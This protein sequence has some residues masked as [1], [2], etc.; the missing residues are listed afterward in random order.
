[1]HVLYINFFSAL[2]FCNNF[3]FSMEKETPE[4]TKWTIEC[5]DG[6][7]K[8]EKSFINNFK[9]LTFLDNVCSQES[10]E[11]KLKLNFGKN[12]I[13]NLLSLIDISK[14]YFNSTISKNTIARMTI[15]AQNIAEHLVAADFLGLKNV[16]NELTFAYARFLHNYNQKTDAITL[17]G[18]SSDF[19]Y[20]ISKAYS[21]QYGERLKSLLDKPLTFTFHELQENN[22][23]P[24]TQLAFKNRFISKSMFSGAL[25]L[26]LSHL[27]LTDLDGIEELPDTQYIILLDL[28]HNY[29]TCIPDIILKKLINLRFI[30]LNNNQIKLE[31]VK[32]IK[33]L[34]YASSRL[35][36]ECAAS[37]LWPNNL[38]AMKTCLLF[39]ACS[40]HNST[41]IAG[42]VFTTIC[43][44][45]CVVKPTLRP[46]IQRDEVDALMKNSFVSDFNQLSLQEQNVFLQSVREET[47]TE[48]KK[49]LW[50][51][52]LKS[53]NID[54][55]G[56]IAAKHTSA[57]INY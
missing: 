51:D 23:L 32:K 26:D 15:D 50:H 49:K 36:D 1:M 25:T 21:L 31:Q 13:N 39:G 33:M 20:D 7:I 19:I 52:F 35:F 29:L 54:I 9:N 17:P 4:E 42:K 16:Y 6:E 43:E 44:W 53:C 5:S 47:N 30:N 11:K 28:S 55:V 27:H 48:R 2:F 34:G 22:R 45:N 18:L 40:L 46:T 8:I 41:T 14:H 3:I 57:K 38:G 37:A 12:T 24:K 56:I 10:Q